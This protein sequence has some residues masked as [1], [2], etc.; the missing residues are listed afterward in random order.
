MILR[1]VGEHG[2]VEMG[3]AN[4]LLHQTERG[5]LHDHVIAAGLCHL[6]IQTHEVVD[7]R[8]GIVGVH[9]LVADLVLDRADQTDPMPCLGEDVFDQV[10]DGRLSVGS[11]H[12]H[13]MHLSLRMSEPSGTE[14]SVQLP[15][16]VCENLPV[17]Q[18]QIVVCQHRSSAALQR[19]S[20]SIVSVKML[21]ANAGEQHPRLHLTGIICQ[22]GDLH[23][24][25]VCLCILFQQCI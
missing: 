8:R 1:Q 2:G 5:N 20:R 11:G 16:V 12:T 15:C 3:H 18:S 6:R 7:E 24:R 21:S 10:G 13:E 9:D 4:A 17:A 23:V 25:Q 14:L 22:T 19:F